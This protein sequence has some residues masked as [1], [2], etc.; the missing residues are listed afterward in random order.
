MAALKLYL[1]RTTDNAASAPSSEQSTSQPNGSVSSPTFACH[2]LDVALG[3]VQTA[4]TLT[5]THP[6][7][8]GVHRDGMMRM[9]ASD[10]LSA[11]TIAAGTWRVG[12]SGTQSNAA[13]DTYHNIVVYVWRPG[14]SS[15]VGAI[16]DA[17][18]GTGFGA[19]IS[20]GRQIISFSGSSVTAQSGDRIIFEWWH[21]W[22]HTMA[23]GY[24]SNIKY[25]DGT[26]L[27][28]IA[29]AEG[30]WIE[31]PQDNLF[32]AAAYSLDCQP[33]SYAVTGT[34]ATIVS[35]RVLSA[36]PGS[37]AIT[38]AS[39]TLSK[40]Y[41]VSAD[42]GTY[43]VT[44]SDATLVSTRV[45]SADPA[46]YTVTGQA[47][48][49]ARGLFLSADPGSYA[50]TGSDATLVSTRVISTDPGV[51]AVTGS[52]ATL[53]RGLFLT[54]D[55]GSYAVSGV[56]AELVHTVVGAYTLDCQPGSYVLTGTAASLVADRALSADP[57]VYTLTGVA[58]EF[59]YSAS[60]VTNRLR[61]L[62]GVGE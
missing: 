23:S 59:V 21:H 48:T 20:D 11:V 38:G 56:A 61:T 22:Q 28:D 4:V 37:Y 53:A 9:F 62:M 30:S 51:Y 27:D 32:S 40:G 13:A 16:S 15:V 33:A 1:R 29:A 36:D 41:F 49:L 42:P 8:S 5:H 14:T 6:N 19:E 24:T 31:C 43:A 52:D 45:L 50:V 7:E 35:T 58:V 47:A 2:D 18:G 57:G 10:A 26:E 44:G 55:P 39:T 34:A 3:A 17:H 12:L 46:V 60:A 25:D 54:A